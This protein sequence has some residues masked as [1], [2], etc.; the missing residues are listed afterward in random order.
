M[1]QVSFKILHD[2]SAGKEDNFLFPLLDDVQ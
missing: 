1:K 2:I